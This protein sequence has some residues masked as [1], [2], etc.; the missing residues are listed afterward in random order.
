MHTTCYAT[1]VL[2][3]DRK[4]VATADCLLPHVRSTRRCTEALDKYLRRFLDKNEFRTACRYDQLS[5]SGHE[6]TRRPIYTLESPPKS[7]VVLFYM[8]KIGL[9]MRA[10]GGGA[11]WVRTPQRHL[12]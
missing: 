5:T 3:A 11:P 2:V 6:D 1:C 8:V 9:H 4:M 7:P 10:G 12:W